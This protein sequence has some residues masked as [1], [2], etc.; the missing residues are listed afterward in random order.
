MFMAIEC[1]CCIDHMLIDVVV[2]GYSWVDFDCIS[3]IDE[4]SI[5]TGLGFCNRDSASKT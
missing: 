2:Q 3:S 1:L 5:T 4:C